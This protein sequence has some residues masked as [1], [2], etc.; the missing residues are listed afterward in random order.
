MNALYA[1]FID[2]SHLFKDRSHCDKLHVGAA[3]KE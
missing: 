3:L 2:P 1:F